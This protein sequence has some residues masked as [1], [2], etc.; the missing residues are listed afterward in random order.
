MPDPVCQTQLGGRPQLPF[1]AKSRRTKLDAT[2]DIRKRHSAEELIFSASSA[3]YQTGQRKAAQLVE[4]AG[5]PRRGPVLAAQLGA[6][7]SCHD[8]FTVEEALGLIIDNDLTKAQYERLRHSAR[9]KGCQLYPPYKAVAKAKSACLP[10]AAALTVK[11]ERASSSLQKI[12]DHTAGRLL[13]LQ[14]EVVEQLSARDADRAEQQ[15]QQQ[16]RQR[17]QLKMISKWGMDGS[18][19]HSQ[20]KQAGVSRDDHAFVIWLVPLRLVSVK[21]DIVWSNPNPS[22]PRFARPISIEFAAETTALIK[23]RT[24]DIE[25]E[26]RGLVPLEAAAATV[27]Y[28]LCMTMVDGKV[29]N[30]VTDTAS[31]QT[32]SICGATPTDT[33]KL[34]AV[35]SRPQTNIQYGI[36]SLHCWIRCL[37]AL[38]RIAYRLDVRKRSVRDPAE[39]LNVEQAKKKVHDNLKRT[40]GLCVDEPRAGGVGNSN[41]GNTAR[42]AFREAAQ[43]AAC[44]GLS[45]DII[46]RIHV[47]LQAVTCFFPLDHEAFASFCRQTAEEYV[48]EYGW[49]YMPVSLHKLLVHSATVAAQCQLPIGAMSEEAAEA[50]N[51]DLRRFRL[52]HTRKDTRLHGMSDL[53]GYMLVNSDPLLSSKGA[54]RRR[55][56]FGPKVGQLLPATMALLADP[57]LPSATEP[58]NDSSSDDD[59]SGSD[60][61]S[62]DV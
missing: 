54:R 38:L 1:P 21:G 51:K 5:S 61:G 41:D 14:E 6:K 49:Y 36:S 28:D 18:S 19:G 2:A 29:V 31:T 8:A 13:Q 3:V 55:R 20:Y 50:S 53:Y 24:A 22:S 45:E 58:G 16:Q 15:Q 4:A 12:L 46:T 11:P 56:Q 40:M 27:S 60:C 34:E 23:E 26:A 42:R 59:S 30:A 47:A 33:N 25:G 39:K 43:F 9:Q 17:P 37:E 10:P 52:R 35:Y 48:R 32:C 62:N 44:T 7:K 57:P